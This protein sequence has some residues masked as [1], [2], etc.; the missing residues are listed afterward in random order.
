MYIEFI[1][2]FISVLNY[3][4]ARDSLLQVM[5]INDSLRDVHYDRIK[6]MM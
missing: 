3:C 2:Q 1:F 6:G 5:M 4:D